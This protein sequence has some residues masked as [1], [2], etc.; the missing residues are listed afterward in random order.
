MARTL[1]VIDIAGPIFARAGKPIAAGLRPQDV[2]TNEFID[3][4]IGL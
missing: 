4:S 1:R 3:S 2:A